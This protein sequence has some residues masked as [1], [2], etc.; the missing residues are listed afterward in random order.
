VVEQHP[1][2]I[3]TRSPRWHPA[4]SKLPDDQRSIMPLVI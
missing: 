4:S 1:L 3:S 2:T